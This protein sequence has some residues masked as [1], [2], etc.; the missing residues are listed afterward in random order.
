M[1]KKL[2]EPSFE[3][4]E[5]HPEFEIRRYTSNIQASVRSQGSGDLVNRGSFQRIAGYIFG[6]NSS[7]QRIAMTAPVLMWQ[8]DDGAS[9]MSFVMPSAYALDD[10]PEPVDVD[11]QLAVNEEEIVASFSF[12]GFSRPSK[13]ARLTKHLQSLVVQEG[14]QQIGP[15]RLAVYD[16][17]TTLPFLRRNEILIPVHMA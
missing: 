14:W 7:N 15:A 4:V 1:A 5:K 3:L 6:R 12:R 17:P 10:L 13:V 9:I 2:E 8:D 16:P 11:L